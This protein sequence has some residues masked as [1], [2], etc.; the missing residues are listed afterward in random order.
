MVEKRFTLAQLTDEGHYL[1]SGFAAGH[2]DEAVAG[3][4]EDVKDVN[5]TFEKMKFTGRR[6]LVDLK[7]AFETTVVEVCRL[8]VCL[9]ASVS[10]S[11]SVS[12]SVCV[13]VCLS[14]S[15]ACDAASCKPP[16]LSVAVSVSLSAARLVPYRQCPRYAAKRREPRRLP[17][18]LSI[19]LYPPKMELSEKASRPSS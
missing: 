7:Q 11:L 18:C 1:M 15:V 6:K 2:D 5:S 9:S 16:L 8:F 12:L 14:I 13:S 10:L 19:C 3:L 17:P 4:M